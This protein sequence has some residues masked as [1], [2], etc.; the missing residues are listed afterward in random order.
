M[1]DLP[2][3]QAL[4]RPDEHLRHGPHGA[5]DDQMDADEDRD[6]QTDAVRVILLLHLRHQSLLVPRPLP[7][8]VAPTQ[9]LF[10][11]EHR[12]GGA[13]AGREEEEDEDDEEE[14]AT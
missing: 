14:D 11:G 5:D 12:Q 13:R 3:Q 8:G 6:G 9:V 10:V 4:S 1:V 2:P 7:H